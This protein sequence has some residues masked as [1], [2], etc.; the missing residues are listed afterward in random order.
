MNLK[1]V[2]KIT[3]LIVILA[4]EIKS[5]IKKDYKVKV[6]IDTDELVKKLSQKNR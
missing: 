6:D 3:L 4:E 5:A 1:Q 2:L